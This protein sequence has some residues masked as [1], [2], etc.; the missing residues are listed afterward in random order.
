[1]HGYYK[2]ILTFDKKVKK[3]LN[4]ARWKKIEVPLDGDCLYH[5]VSR[6]LKYHDLIEFKSKHI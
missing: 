2:D 6:S 1:M 5:A 4:Q 3:I